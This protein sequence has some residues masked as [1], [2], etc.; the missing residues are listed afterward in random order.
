MSSTFGFIDVSGEFVI[1]PIY[2]GVTDFAEGRAG[3]RIDDRE[4]FVSRDGREV[5]PL[6]FAQVESFSEGL[7]AVTEWNSVLAAPTTS[8]AR[9]RAIREQEKPV[10]YIDRAGNYA[11]RPTFIHADPFS[12]GLAWVLCDVGKG[13][14]TNLAGDI[15][16]VDA[17]CLWE[18]SEGYARFSTD[19]WHEGFLDTELRVVIPPIYEQA[20]DFCEGLA[21]AIEDLDQEQSYFLNAD[22]ERVLSFDMRCEGEF[23]YGLLGVL[24][25]DRWGFVDRNGEQVIPPAF[26]SIGAGFHDG[27]SAIRL[28]GK[29]G[30]V[31]R[32]GDIVVKPRFDQEWEFSEGLAAVKVGSS[33]GFI[34]ATDDM[35]IEPRFLEGARFREGLASAE[36]PSDVA[37]RLS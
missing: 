21:W 26:E 24:V 7:A 19:D 31:D 6:K 8:R 16:P 17:A 30:F 37:R 1:A 28:N 20:S 4:G 5:I 9:A 18:F 12:G 35:V 34:N 15:R 27:L 22:G 3:V 10:G 36:V 23:K 33:W 32:Q 14:V 25:G 13:G 2:H 11:M 29:W